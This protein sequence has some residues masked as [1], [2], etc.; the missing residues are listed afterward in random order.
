MEP[1][2]GGQLVN[3]LPK[4]IKQ[5]FEGFAPG[6]SSAAWSLRWIWNHPEVTVVLSGMNEQEQLDDNIRTASEMY[7]G[8]FKTEE[9]AIYENIKKILFEKTKVPCTGCAYCMPCPAGV[10]IPQVF[11]LY[12][13]K[14][15]MEG[16]REKFKYMMELGIAAK[17]PG[18]ASLCIQCGKCEQHCPQNIEIRKE[19]KNAAKEMEGILF[20]PLTALIRRM[21]GVR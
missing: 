4:E 17:K 9:L 16:K 7:P 11:S 21:T 5:L 1:L 15:L 3:Q 18:F 20:K 10:N 2:R 6:R 13:E 12:N 8:S 19:L 14:Y